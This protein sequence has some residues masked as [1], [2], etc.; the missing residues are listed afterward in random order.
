LEQIEN[1]ASEC[2]DV[3]EF[4]QSESIGSSRSNVSTEL[5]D[6]EAGDGEEGRSSEEFE[7]RGGDEKCLGFHGRF[8]MS[9]E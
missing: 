4:G 3:F 1:G 5:A 7:G 2:N 6:D 8:G 9:V